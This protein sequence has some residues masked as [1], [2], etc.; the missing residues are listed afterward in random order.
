MRDSRYVFTSESVT[1][2]HPDKLCDRMSDAIVGRHLAAEPTAR[3]AAE[4]A[5]STGIVFVS[6]KLR[7]RA[8]VDIAT[9]VRDV[10][11]RTRYSASELDARTCTVVTSIHELPDGRR[12]PVQT[13]LEDSDLDAIVAEDQATVFGFACTHTAALAPL[14]IWLAHKIAR[15][16]SA[17]RERELPY[18]SPDGKTQVAVELRRERPARIFGVTVLAPPSPDAHPPIERLRRD[19]HDHVIRT[20]FLDEELKPDANTRITI[21]PEGTT[22]GGPAMHAG[23]TG[24]KAAVD[25]YGEF[26]RHSGSALS[27]KDI[28]RIDRIGVYAAR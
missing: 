8:H 17:A 27:G 18:L 1:S 21:N 6:V 3:V 10:I 13:S 22:N 9:L 24:R 4:C 14:P 20:A 28:G 26:A 7:S 15:G 19:V 16:L 25:T 2:G 12:P 23:L 11:R 5:V